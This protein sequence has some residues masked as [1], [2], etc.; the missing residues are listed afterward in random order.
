MNIKAAAALGQTPA[1]GYIIGSWE[2]VT[3][4]CAVAQ[5][6]NNQNGDFTGFWNFNSGNSGGGAFSR[7]CSL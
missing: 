6:G 7:V 1:R 4:G 5:Y 2:H 3:A